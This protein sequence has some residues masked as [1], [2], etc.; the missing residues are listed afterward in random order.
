MKMKES[1]SHS[2][3]SNYLQPHGLYH[4]WNSPGKNTGLG[5]LPSPGEFP[6]P[7]IEPRSPKY[8]ADSLPDKPPGNPKNT[9]VGSLSLLQRVFPTQELNLGLLHCRQTLYQLSYQ[10]ISI[11]QG[12]TNL[13]FLL[14]LFIFTLPFVLY[15][16][17]ST[18][19][20]K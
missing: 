18:S 11:V 7:G 6:N 17:C 20:V 9:G 3:V 14:D 16:L 1:E 8:R 15:C 13:F 12:R 19:F 5:S 2:V 10:G 4:P